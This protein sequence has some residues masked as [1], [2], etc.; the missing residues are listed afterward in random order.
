MSEVFDDRLLACE[1]PAVSVNHNDVICQ[2]SG[3]L[4]RITT[5][6]GRDPQIGE[7]P[8]TCLVH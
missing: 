4:N 8:N 5:S 6:Y 3:Q 1:L 7:L 2:E